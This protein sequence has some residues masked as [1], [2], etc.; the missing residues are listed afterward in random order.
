MNKVDIA[1]KIDSIEND[2]ELLKNGHI[3]ELEKIPGVPKCSTLA[4]RMK[5]DLHVIISEYETLLEEQTVNVDREQFDLL[6]G[7][8]KRLSEEVAT[9][10]KKQPDALINSFKIGQINRVLNPLKEIMQEEPSAKFLDILAEPDSEG[11]SDKSRNTYSD[12]ALIL[13]QFL[14]ACVQYR[15]KHYGKDWDD[16]RL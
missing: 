7:L 5:N 9:L 1:I 3:H 2:L 16:I 11:K 8:L 6:T 4:N 15:E 10:S 13:S 12:T 14:A